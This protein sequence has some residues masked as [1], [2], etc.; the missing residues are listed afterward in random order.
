MAT[1]AFEGSVT[2][3]I[4]AAQ[5]AARERRVKTVTVDGQQRTIASPF[6]SPGDWRDC[7]IYFLLLD[8]FN[9]P[10]A[11][12]NGAWNQRFDFRQGGTFAEC[13]RSWGIWN[14]WV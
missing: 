12:P 1:D 7:W 9:N 6:P 4:A 3:A 8:R 13:R 2:Q 5:G 14:G 11:R 10:V